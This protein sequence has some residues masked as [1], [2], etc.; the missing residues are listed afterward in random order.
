MIEIA[1]PRR[2]AHHALAVL[3]AAMLG[4]TLFAVLWTTMLG[5]SAGVRSPGPT[6]LAT[7]AVAFWLGTFM[8]MLPSA[9]IVFSLL[10]PVTRRRTAAAGWI[11]LLAGAATGILL[12][13]L[14]SPKLHGTTPL[15]L[16]AFALIGAGVAALYRILLDRL[17]RSG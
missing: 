12:A 5:I 13:P 8:I 10:W 7:L 6:W 1:P 15:Q 9:T 11:C 2:F 14:A 16:I 3:A 17:G 4:A